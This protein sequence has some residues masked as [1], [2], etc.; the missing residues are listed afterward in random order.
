MKLIVSIGFLLLFILNSHAEGTKQ[1]MPNNN[2][3]CYVQFNESIGGQRYFAMS[4]N[5]D[6]LHRLYI[7][8]ANAGEVIHVGFKKLASSSGNAQ[9]RIK[10]PD[11][12]VVYGFTAIPTSGS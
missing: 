8:I 10:D 11:G 4:T 5:T 1:L 7:H 3:Y 9:F 12:N 2:G 6:T